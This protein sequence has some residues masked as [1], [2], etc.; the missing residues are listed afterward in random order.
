M[1]RGSEVGVYGFFTD[2]GNEFGL[3]TV[4]LDLSKALAAS[5]R[6]GKMSGYDVR[7]GNK[8]WTL[9]S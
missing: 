5:R 4:D 1:P 7:L 8:R 2:T 9:A 6:A 3:R